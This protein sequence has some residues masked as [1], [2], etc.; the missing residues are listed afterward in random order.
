MKLPDHPIATQVDAY[1]F[2]LIMRVQASSETLYENSTKVNGILGLS[3]PLTGTSTSSNYIELMYQ[4]GE[5]PNPN[6]SLI[7]AGEVDQSSITLGDT[8][9]ANVHKKFDYGEFT[10]T[11]S[12]GAGWGIDSQGFMLGDT[13]ITSGNSVYSSTSSNI[14]LS[15]DSYQAWVTEVTKAEPALNCH[16]FDYCGT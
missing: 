7:L 2:F 3:S 16:D 15:Y 1:E 6:F 4:K 8:N 14:E 13:K 5:I 9:Y 12:G 10:M 11:N